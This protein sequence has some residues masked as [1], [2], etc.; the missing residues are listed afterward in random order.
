MSARTSTANRKRVDGAAAAAEGG[1]LFLDEVA[2]PD[3]SVQAKPLQLLQIDD[4][5]PASAARSRQEAN[6]GINIAARTRT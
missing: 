4:V 5:L 6:V 1:T 3:P 2:T